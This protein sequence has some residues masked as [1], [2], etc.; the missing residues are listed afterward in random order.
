MPLKHRDS[1]VLIKSD[2]QTDWVTNSESERQKINRNSISDL[3][4]MQ[5]YTQ[6]STSQMKALLGKETNSLLGYNPK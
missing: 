5:S 1:N 6:S 3:H 2:D 4:Q